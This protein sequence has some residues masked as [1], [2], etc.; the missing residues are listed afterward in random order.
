MKLQI[1]YDASPSCCYVE[2]E[3]CFNDIILHVHKHFCLDDL[4]DVL[5]SGIGSMNREYEN[6]VE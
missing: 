3:E 4:V 5:I 1:I 2:H 6:H